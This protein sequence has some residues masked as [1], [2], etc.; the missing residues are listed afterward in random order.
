M[1]VVIVR[2]A[3]DTMMNMPRHHGNDPRME[4][5]S[6]LGVLSAAVGL[7]LALLLGYI[8]RS[9]LDTFGVIALLVMAIV[10]T[11]GGVW[12]VRRRLWAGMLIATASLVT[13]TGYLALLTRCDGCSAGVLLGNVVI[14]FFYGAPGVLIIRWR[15]FLR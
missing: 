13:A 8:K 14:A 2:G 4:V 12:L 6:I 11:I 10:L 3:G 15:R 7:L 9:L 5:L 1:R